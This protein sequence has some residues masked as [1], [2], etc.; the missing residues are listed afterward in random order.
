[1]KARLVC[2]LGLLAFAGADAASA[3]W[4]EPVPGVLNVDPAHEGETANIASIGGTPYLAWDEDGGGDTWQIRV[5]RLES[6]GWAS[7]GGSLNSD[8]SHDAFAADVADVGGVPYVVWEEDPGSFQFQIRVKR[9]EAG[10]WTAVG[11][12]QNVDSAHDVST[13]AIAGVGG[14][15]YITWSENDGT[16]RYQVRVKRL[17]AGAFAAVGGSLNISAAETAGAPRIADVGGVPYVTWSEDDGTAAQVRVKRLEAGTWVSVGGSLNVTSTEDADAPSIASIGGVPY[18]A[19][20]ESDGVTRQLRV[21]RF[22]G[23]AWQPVGG[24]LLDDP[25]HGAS[26]PNIAGVGATPVV[27]WSQDTGVEY[28]LDVKRFDGTGWTPLGGNP[29]NIDASRSANQPEPLSIGGVPYVAFD[30]Y[31]ATAKRIRV[32]RLEPDIVSEGATPSLTGAT[33]S[34]Q[35]DDF[36]LPLPVGFEYGTT[37]AFGTTTALQTTTGAGASTVTQ[38][39]G[40]L[41]PATAY[42]FRGFGSDGTRQTSLGA[43]Q[44]FTT[45]APPVALP[46]LT[47]LKLTPA[48]FRAS[49]GTLVTYTDSVAA[50]TTLTVQRPSVG[51]RKGGA[52]VKA[53]K[54]P[55]KAKRCTRYAKVRSLT[56]T[57]VA[58]AN[59]LRLKDRGLKPGAYRLRAVP[60]NSAGAGKAV[61]KRFRVKRR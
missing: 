51:L 54:R 44:T 17:E 58:G 1:M 26:S 8:S 19:F 36:G 52:C 13:A 6:G 24:S 10:S 3:N 31:D 9:L 25:A 4:T 21:K 55:P 49:K 7:V 61:T 2:L 48:T 14:V 43:T 30:E 50:T 60:R 53:R 32:K 18:V 59:R 27:A 16:G 20:N 42:S 23:T 22:D 28:L 40:G 39:V 29:L 46:V 56:H 34:A 11:G 35:I 33:L 45:L 15:P 12:V 57:D 47:A 37:A 41:M 38:D 5:K